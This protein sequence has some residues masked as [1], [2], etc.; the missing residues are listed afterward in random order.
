MTFRGILLT[1]DDDGVHSS[2]TDIDEAQLP[3]H[4]VTINVS[5]STVNYK[6]GMAVMGRPGIVREY[7]MVPGIDVVGTVES[8]ADDAWAPGTLVTINGF[9]VGEAHWGGL[10]LSLIHI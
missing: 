1:K 3:D 6:D 4:D 10:A 2:I 5:H 9:D 7:P 8:S